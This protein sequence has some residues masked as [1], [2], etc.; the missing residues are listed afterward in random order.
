MRNLA[1]ALALALVC[2]WVYHPCLHGAWL[3]DDG[4]EISQNPV[5]RSAGG[6]WQP[7]VHP[8]GMDYFPLKGTVQWLEWHLWGANPFGYHVV[9]LAL[10][11]AGALLVWRLLFALGVPAAYLGGLL[12]AVHPLAVES[13]AWISELKN[14]LSL[15][16]LLMAA[17]AVVRFDAGGRRRDQ[18]T[19]LLGFLAALLC[20]TSVVM[21]PFLILLLAWW[22]RGRIGARDLRA[23]APFFA[24]AAALGLVTVWFQS[25]R[26]IGIAGTPQPLLQRLG[27]AGWSIEEY[28][29]M[30]AWPSG[31]SPI[32]APGAGGFA[33]LI[34]WLG[35]AAVLG[36]LWARRAGWGRH[37]LLGVGWYLLNLAPVLGLVPMAY[38]RVSP[39]ADHLAYLP[40]VGLA[41]LAAA[42]LGSA[43][44]RA[45]G[46]L[47]G[48]AAPRLALAAVFGI[49]LGALAIESHALAASYRDEKTLWTFA[50]ERNPA[51]WLARNNLGKVFLQEG[52]AGAAEAEF[53]AAVAIQADS[54]EAHANL[55]NALAAEGREDEARAEY[56]AALAIDPKFAGARY[57]L[58]L[59]LL[60]SHRLAEAA[61]QFQEALSLEPGRAQARNSLG[62]ALAG[63]GRLD[64]AME[65]YEGALKADPG[66]PEAHL[67]LGNA[68]FRK[69]RAEEAVAQY[70]E[71]IR[72]EP[73]YAAAHYNLAQA[74]LRLGRADEARAELEAAKAPANH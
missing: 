33:A 17:V 3:W 55:G 19:A 6:W 56:A 37:G 62:L 13:V 59:S 57:N 22:R 25:T 67:N 73:G 1:R 50:V 49:A 36:V 8:Q 9:S 39:R 70:R 42:A 34:P 51:A 14:T 7:W 11:V 28:A 58:G 63:E 66:L 41:G 23:S 24:V 27:Q 29:R 10:H 32:Y 47:G 40:I 74:L 30:F 2:L 16:L 48:G 69:G 64:E 53:R 65:Q 61:G 60:R 45:E 46:R 43:L 54:L 71:A 35:L 31:I 44:R 26:A 4:L 68:L 72:L 15:P 12:F 5:V 20:K 38:S 18:V 52:R 21:L